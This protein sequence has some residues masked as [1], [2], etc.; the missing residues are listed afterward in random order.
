M[1]DPV[2]I[3]Y[4][5]WFHE[6]N[7]WKGMHYK[8]VR[9]LKLPS[10]M[11]NYQE[12]I[13]ER[14]IRF[15]VETG[16]RHGGSALFFADHVEARDGLVISC[17]I[18]KNANMVGSH[19]RIRFLIGNSAAPGAA[20]A[21]AALLPADRRPGE[22]FFI[23]DSDHS[24]PHV[25]AELEVFRALF[26]PGDTVIVEDT[27]VNGHPVRPDHG[28]GPMEAVLGFIDRYPGLLEPDLKREEKFG[29][30]L[31]PKGYYRVRGA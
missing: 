8:G 7:V 28:P 29:A 16:T 1:Q 27:V 6:T 31:A 4:L 20:A 30:T 11:W 2:A 14:N 24:A 23:F 3:A 5:K 25:S 18:D 26:L 13:H 19:P 9:T 15:V 21:I 22:T 10:D 12:I 17:D